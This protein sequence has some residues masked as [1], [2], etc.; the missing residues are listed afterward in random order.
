[1]LMASSSGKITAH[2]LHLLEDDPAD[3]SGDGRGEMMPDDDLD[4]RTADSPSSVESRQLDDS[5][6]DDR[7]SPANLREEAKYQEELKERVKKS[8]ADLGIEPEGVLL[9]DSLDDTPRDPIEIKEDLP[10]GEIRE[11]EYDSRRKKEIVDSEVNDDDV[12]ST[13]ELDDGRDDHGNEEE[14]HLEAEVPVNDDDEDENFLAD[15]LEAEAPNH[16]GQSDH[17]AESED[18]TVHQGDDIQ[19]GN[20][21]NAPD[22][23]VSNDPH[24]EDDEEENDFVR[25]SL[26]TDRD[27]AELDNLNDSNP[28]SL[29]EVDQDQ[30][31]GDASDSFPTPVNQNILDEK[32]PGEPSD[33]F[34]S[35]SQPLQPE[36]E[37]DDGIADPFHEGSDKAND[38]SKEETFR[39]DAG[40]VSERPPSE[41][42]YET[43]N[44]NR[45]LDG[46]DGE[47]DDGIGEKN[48]S[49]SQ[50]GVRPFVSDTTPLEHDYGDD[51][52]GQQSPAALRG[53][54]FGE[55]YPDDDGR[56]SEK[57]PVHSHI[58]KQESRE[59][60]PVLPK[61]SISNSNN[62][63]K[64]PHERPPSGGSVHSGH[65]NLNSRRSSSR[66]RDPT[67][68]LSSPGHRTT[69]RNRTPVRS[70]DS[71]RERESVSKQSQRSRTRQSSNDRSRQ[72]SSGRS[73]QV[74][75]D[76]VSPASPQ[77]QSANTN[78]SLKSRDGSG[79]P[80]DQSSRNN[81]SR[82]ENGRRGSNDINIPR[83]SRKGMN[84]SDIDD[85]SSKEDLR[86][87][88][89]RGH[90]ARNGSSKFRRVPSGSEKA[91]TVESVNAGSNDPLSLKPPPGPLRQNVSSPNAAKAAGQVDSTGKKPSPRD[92]M[93]PGQRLELEE[94][95]QFWSDMHQ[96]GVFNQPLNQS[97][98]N[99]STVNPTSK[100]RNDQI[101]KVKLKSGEKVRVEYISDDSDDED[102]HFVDEK[103]SPIDQLGRPLF[104]PQTPETPD[105]RIMYRIKPSPPRQKSNKKSSS[106]KQRTREVSAADSSRYGSGYSTRN[107]SGQKSGR[108]GS[109]IP[110]RQLVDR[111]V[112]PIE[113]EIEISPV[114]TQQE[115]NLDSTLP[116]VT[117]VESPRER[118]VKSACLQTGL[119]DLP[120]PEDVEGSELKSPVQEVSI[121][122]SDEHITGN[123]YNT[124]PYQ[125]PLQSPRHTGE[126]RPFGQ[127][128]VAPFQQQGPEHQP[129]PGY[130]QQGQMP[131]PAG[132]YAQPIPGN[133]Q[134]SPQAHWQPVMV[135]PGY[136]SQGQQFAAPLQPQF[137]DPLMNPGMNQQIPQQMMPNYPGQQHHP[138][139]HPQMQDPMQQGPFQQ[140]MPQHPHSGL[141]YQYQPNPQGPFASPGRPIPVQDMED[142]YPHERDTSGQSDRKQPGP[143]R[144]Q[145]KPKHNFIDINKTSAKLRRDPPNKKYTEGFQQ[146][147][148]LRSPIN[149]RQPLP[150]ISR[151][152]SLDDGQESSTGWTPHGSATSRSNDQW[153]QAVIR[154]QQMIM[155]ARGMSDPNIYPQG[156]G[157][158]PP[159]RNGS[160]P[161]NYGGGNTYQGG[162]PT[163]DTNL[164]QVNGQPYSWSADRA[165]AYAR[166]NAMQNANQ[167]GVGGPFS[168]DP[169]G[170][171]E[172]T[173]TSPRQRMAY[174]HPMPSRT[175]PFQV[176]P[177]IQNSGRTSGEDKELRT[178]DPDGYLLKLQKQKQGPQYKPYTLK[179][180]QNLK[181]DFKFGGLGPDKETMN[182]RNEKVARQRDYARQVMEQNKKIIR[183]SPQASHTPGKDSPQTEASKRELMLAYA[184][185]VPLPRIRNNNSP[186]DQSPRDTRSV[187]LEYA[188]HIPKPPAPT[189]PEVLHDRLYGSGANSR[190]SESGSRSSSVREEAFS[191]HEENTAVEMA[192][193]QEL[194]E[195]HQQEKNELDRLR[196]GLST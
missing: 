17:R 30:F 101:E 23:G 65:S 100:P 163:P 166:M 3:A 172:A 137:V 176:L 64:G 69:S 13:E 111:H 105:L 66:Q 113:D 27:E 54:Q 50:N 191:T 29:G 43:L 165:N 139:Y 184:D 49:G 80:R 115:G 82:K 158:P 46:N 89:S 4:L 77:A 32:D 1:M 124:L 135:Q 68:V 28:I 99:P 196:K 147:K 47:S 126:T 125:S 6:V 141:Q 190:N 189:P 40:P 11:G 117:Q 52:K 20:N 152:S 102:L 97:I 92:F 161:G 131:F 59:Q 93:T 142:P 83:Y 104:A 178:S 167:P 145:P 96:A 120:T 24:F 18:Y 63:A 38:Q 98:A 175:S 78:G 90:G 109:R 148:G 116:P 162:Y 130:N 106:G 36:D 60:S 10:Y 37:D 140:Q 74:P 75:N 7:A 164:N 192:R 87:S 173:Q 188:K 159:M 110:V 57:P 41:Q 122:T 44:R 182:I 144:Q 53:D 45:T 71:S 149:P 2:N 187:A 55:S 34:P 118:P 25:D 84:N 81:E 179:D 160:L 123:N 86:N 180:F 56:N 121:Q 94:N 112:S 143:I 156:Q 85:E 22:V 177:D 146:K 15:S 16:Q 169:R 62:N 138:Q 134:G 72:T 194:T 103:G 42:E 153:A 132:A 185:S 195:R 170:S 127:V 183:A 26:E 5:P 193:L 58:G 133:Y 95:K 12:D 48:N 186:A 70:R 157:P 151:E 61:P 108:E 73:R 136:P 21:D 88:P 8:F 14:K 91:Q 107:G 174:T 33:Q 181:K 9:K 155:L 171:Y 35:L 128:R 51:D 31:D 67:G 150:Q 119:D 79:G 154:E 76:R 168:V 129:P 39:D 19:P 114:E